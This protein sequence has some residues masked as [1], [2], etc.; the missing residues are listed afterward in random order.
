M[1]LQIEVPQQ[2]AAMIST[3]RGNY[4]S[5]ILDAIRE[6]FTRENIA[7]KNILAEGYMNSREE[8]IE[9]C[10]EFEISDLENIK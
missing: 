5:F 4:E 3:F 2:I 6:K 9:I 1:L 10:N 7:E 8:D